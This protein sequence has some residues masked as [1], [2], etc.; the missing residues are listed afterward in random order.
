MY[1]FNDQITA[2]RKFMKYGMDIMP[3]VNY[4]NYTFH[5][6]TY[7]ITNMTV[8]WIGVEE[9]WWRMRNKC[10]TEALVFPALFHS[11]ILCRTVNHSAYNYAVRVLYRMPVLFLSKM[12]KSCPNN[13]ENSEL[14]SKFLVM[15]NWL[16]QQKRH[17]A[18]HMWVTTTF[19][20]ILWLIYRRYE[21]LSIQANNI[22]WNGD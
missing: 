7:S 18:E 10:E 2:G 4:P 9:V 8:A 20:F 1:I 17:N 6:P 15:N 22:V 11:F 13:S 3:Y 5:L 14:S 16:G 12:L 21:Q 19:I